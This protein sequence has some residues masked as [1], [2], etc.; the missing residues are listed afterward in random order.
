MRKLEGSI[1]IAIDG[2]GFLNKENRSSLARLFEGYV[3]DY[4]AT[5]AEQIIRT[6]LYE[7]GGMRL[8]V[9]TSFKIK[10]ET[11]EAILGLYRRLSENFGDASG[12]AI[13]QKFLIDLGGMRIC[14]PGLEDLQREERDHRIRMLAAEGKGS[15]ELSIMFDLSEK[16]IRTIYKGRRSRDVICSNCQNIFPL[17]AIHLEYGRRKQRQSRKTPQNLCR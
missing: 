1:I 10:T 11:R 9:P 17:S 7:L 15:L 13:M 6:I 14:F 8:T 12:R 4:G 2:R 3:K 5:A 16:Y